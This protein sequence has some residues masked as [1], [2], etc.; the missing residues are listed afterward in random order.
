M[1]LLHGMGA[2][3]GLWLLNL[4]HFSTHRKI[5]AIDLP[6]FGRSFRKKHSEKLSAEDAETEFISAVESWR[7][8]MNLNQFILLGHSL[9]GYLAS[10]YA[11][12]HS[13]FVKGLILVDS[14]GFPRRS[15]D[16]GEKDKN[17]TQ[18]PS[19]TWRVV[20]LIY[21][22]VNPNPL[23]VLRVAGPLGPSLISKYRPDLV[24]KFKHKNMKEDSIIANYVY[25]CNAQEPRLNHHNYSGEVAFKS[26]VEGLA[27][28]KHPMIDRIGHLP[29]HI[30]I[31]MI[32]GRKSW[33]D[34]NICHEVKK[35]RGQGIVNVEIIDHAGHHVYADQSDVFNKT[36]KKTCQ[37]YD[38]LYQKKLDDT[39]ALS[40][41]DLFL[42]DDVDGADH[43]M[44]F[45][46]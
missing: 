17:N 16:E 31:T 6:G 29:S 8:S 38:R 2:G 7:K 35:I 10:A 39:K 4:E 9:G 12:Q 13:Q 18:R 1:V 45:S 37:S 30:P 24:Q 32:N 43:V 41:K 23:S 40:N 21:T 19:L 22:T 44:N 20:R 42:C 14:W 27:W 15:V 26:M 34:Y 36:V 46:L 28:A 5:Y 25:H 33:V 3:V 11:L